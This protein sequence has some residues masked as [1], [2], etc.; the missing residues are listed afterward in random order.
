[1]KDLGDSVPGRAGVQYNII[2]DDDPNFGVSPLLKKG[3]AGEE[4]QGYGIGPEF[5]PTYGMPSGPGFPAGDPAGGGKRRRRGVRGTRTFPRGILRK[6]SKVMPS[7]NPSKSPPTRK[8]SILIVSEKKVKDARK[9]AKAKASK[10]DIGT[11]RKRL[12]EKKIISSEKKN[13]PPAILRTLYIDAVGA[14][15]LS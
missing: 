11:I 13:I 2:K 12:V 5:T 6:T 8:R 3:G 10:T 4:R 7:R 1:M 14:G 15:L 9:S